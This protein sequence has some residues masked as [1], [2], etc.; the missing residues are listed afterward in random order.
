MP[1][2]TMLLTVLLVI[3]LSGCLEEEAKVEVKQES[4][5]ERVLPIAPIA[6]LPCKKSMSAPI[7]DK[8]K[9]KNMLEKS[10]RITAD[11]SPQQIDKV[12]NNYIRKKNAAFKDCQKK[13]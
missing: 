1:K 10:G 5:A 8:T 13:G 6:K 7:K 11:M 12:V 3:T 9:I 2:I 4:S